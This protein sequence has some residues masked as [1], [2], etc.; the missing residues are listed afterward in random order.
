MRFSFR[1]NRPHMEVHEMQVSSSWSIVAIGLYLVAVTAFLCLS[2]ALTLRLKTVT[3]RR[4]ALPALVGLAGFTLLILFL[5]GS[6]TLSALGALEL[7]N[8]PHKVSIDSVIR[9]IASA[10]ELFCGTLVAYSLAMGRIRAATGGNT[11]DRDV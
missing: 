8:S 6:D 11:N 3:E 1:L 5:T 2:I 7:K 10:G 4:D 9:T